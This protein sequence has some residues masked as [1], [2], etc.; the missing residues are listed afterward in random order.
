MLMATI[1]QLPLNFFKIYILKTF[2]E[3]VEIVDVEMGYMRFRTMVYAFQD[4]V[5]PVI[6]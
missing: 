6:C 1:E 2:I 3:M 5:I 4:K